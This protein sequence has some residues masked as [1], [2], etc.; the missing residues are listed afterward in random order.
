M[1][2][3]DNINEINEA[4]KAGIATWSDICLKADAGEWAFLLNYDTA[5]V[6]NVCLLFQHICSNIGIKKGLIN[7]EKAVEYG[8]R[9]HDLVQDMTGVDTRTYYERKK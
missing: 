4:I 8:N 7:E 3:K 5:D 1:E 6:M 2:S 9:L